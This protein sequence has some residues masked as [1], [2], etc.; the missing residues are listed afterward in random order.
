MTS[1]KR[2]ALFI[3][4]AFNARD[5]IKWITKDVLDGLDRIIMRHQT[6]AVIFPI[7]LLRISSESDRVKITST[8]GIWYFLIV[9]LN[10]WVVCWYCPFVYPF[11]FFDLTSHWLSEFHWRLSGKNCSFLLL[12]ARWL[13]VYRRRLGI[14]TVIMTP[15]LK[16]RWNEWRQNPCCVLYS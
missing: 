16:D 8:I 9:C 2:C 13:C 10:I 14:N 6:D 1:L 11:H 7:I 15:S 4:F 12:L 3:L 5:L